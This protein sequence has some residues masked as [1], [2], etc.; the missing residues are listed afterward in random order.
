MAVP[1]FQ[2]LMR[3]TLVYLS[4]GSEQRTGDI[5]DGV[6]DLLRLTAE[7]RAERLPSGNGF[8][9]ANRVHWALVYLH[10]AAAVERPSRAMYRI[11][12]RGTELLSQHPDAV[13]VPAL[14]AFPE[15]VAFRTRHRPAAV[16]EPA[17]A[18]EPERDPVESMEQALVD[19][20]AA[21][22]GELLVRIM[23]SSPQFFEELVLDLLEAMG[24]GGEPTMRRHL[25]GSGDEGVDGVIDEDRLGLDQLYVQAKR[26]SNPV[27]RRE[28][29]GFVGAL[30][31][32][33]AGKG[34]FITTSTFNQN[35]REY[36][37]GL[38]RRVVLIDG[39]RLGELLVRHGVG[40]RTRRA[41]EVKE[42]DDDYFEEE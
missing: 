36:A 4:D 1:N 42:I 25:G 39:Q 23:E 26:W 17:Q 32:K 40:V 27:G 12:Q 15:F 10:A 35:A 6:G 13:R 31:G 29:Q 24:Y 18:E 8:R 7:Q 21:L 2:E 33:R 16:G 38:T 37:A 28:I 14:M 30:E 11:T 41:F 9:F 3:P 5:R 22:A 20:E 34:V 19:I